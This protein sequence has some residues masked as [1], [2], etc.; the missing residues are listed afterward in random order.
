MCGVRQDIYIMF[1]YLNNSNTLEALLKDTLVRGQF[2]LRP[3]SQNPVFL[4]SHTNSVFLHSLK[5]TAPVTDIFL[6]SA[7]ESFHYIKQTFSKF[8]FTFS[9]FQNIVAISFYEMKP[10]TNETLF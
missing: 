7:H 9:F 5:R 8:Y 3:A 6:E 1:E 4:N 2:Y 10:I